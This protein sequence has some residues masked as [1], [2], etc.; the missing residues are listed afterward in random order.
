MRK[1]LRNTL[2]ALGASGLLAIPAGAALAAGNGPGYGTSGGG[3]APATCIHEQQADRMQLRDATG[4]SATQTP[5]GAVNRQSAGACDCDGSIGTMP[6]DGT[7]NQ[8]GK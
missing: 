8:Y 5:R 1:S 6:R 4:Q 3:T 2:V 7:G